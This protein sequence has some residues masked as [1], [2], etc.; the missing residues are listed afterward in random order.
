MKIWDIRTQ[1]KVEDIIIAKDILVDLFNQVQWDSYLLFK[2]LIVECA[3]MICYNSACELSA[4]SGNLYGEVPK[5]LKGHPW[6]GC[7]SLIAAR[8]FKSLLLRSLNL[9]ERWTLKSSK[10]SW[11]TELLMINSIS[12]LRDRNESSSGNTSNKKNGT[13]TNKQ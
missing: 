5:R 9:I 2:Q 8:G 1:M 13:L 4:A 12:C 7:R 11:Q 10:S 6:K 3:K